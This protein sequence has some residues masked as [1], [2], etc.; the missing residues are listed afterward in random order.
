[1]SAKKKMKGN[2]MD[3]TIRPNVTDERFEFQIF[4]D[5]PE[6]VTMREWKYI[7]AAWEQCPTG[8]WVK[9]TMLDNSPRKGA[10]CA[11][12]SWIQI[13]EGKNAGRVMSDLTREN[14]FW[15]HRK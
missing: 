11:L 10:M 13:V 8:K 12:R 1:M 3:E 4:D 14:V 9:V 15:I 5:V 7:R 6:G 2:E